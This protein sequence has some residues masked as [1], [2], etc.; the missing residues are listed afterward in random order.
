[1]VR[2]DTKD[3]ALD[4]FPIDENGNEMI[5]DEW[6]PLTR[7]DIA[8]AIEFF[9]E[10]EPY[11]KPKEKKQEENEPCTC[12]RRLSHCPNDAQCPFK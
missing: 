2:D 9:T 11:T 8:D 4:H 1:M 10:D 5:Q 6:P 7:Q 3:F 12:Y